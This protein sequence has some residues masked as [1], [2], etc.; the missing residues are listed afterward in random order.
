M[1]ATAGLAGVCALVAAAGAFFTAASSDAVY[2]SSA[3]VSDY[4]ALL[5]GDQLGAN[6]FSL[7]VV[8]R[9][10]AETADPPLE[11][12][13]VSRRVTVTGP[14][15]DGRR[16]ITAAA[17][18]PSA[19]RD[20]AAIYGQQYVS[21]RMNSLNAQVRDR[22]RAL[23][24][25]LRRLDGAEDRARLREQ[26]VLLRRA[27]RSAP[28]PS[29]SRRASLPDSPARPTPWRNALIALVAGALLAILFRRLTLRLG[30]TGDANAV[31]AASR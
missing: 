14:T 18:K 25:Q 1:R 5:K 19:A 30:D 4:L 11:P 23:R 3:E 8:A 2:E 27:E 20:L 10:T 24:S 9:L 13:D 26:I 7:E 29:I 6:L 17:P 21:H 22:R 16:T 31:G 12:A 28:Q 15:R